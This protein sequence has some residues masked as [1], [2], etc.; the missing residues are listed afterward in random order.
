MQSPIPSPVTAAYEMFIDNPEQQF[1]AVFGKEEDLARFGK[2][3][4]NVVVKNYN[5]AA[6]NL[7]ATDVRKALK[8]N[9]DISQYLPSEINQQDYINALKGNIQEGCGCIH[10][11]QPN[12]FKSALASLTK[13]MLDQGLNITPLP[14]VKIVNNDTENA[15]N[16]L[17]KT[18]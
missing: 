4:P 8:T 18:A 6:G 17:G 1:I 2:I 7:S 5:D 15:K 12:D 13:Y 3:P 10:S 14:K 16:I 11:Q 9:Q